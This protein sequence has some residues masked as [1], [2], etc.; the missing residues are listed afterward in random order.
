MDLHIF[1]TLNLFN[2]YGL[3]CFGIRECRHCAVVEILPSVFALFFRMF[4]GPFVVAQ[5]KVNLLEPAVIVLVRRRRRLVVEAVSE[6]HHI[7]FSLLVPLVENHIIDIDIVELAELDRR[8]VFDEIFFG[9]LVEVVAVVGVFLLAC[10]L[11]KFDV[12]R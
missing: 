9:F 3:L 2:H 4:V 12:N 1:L 11:R 5:Q 10:F 8:C 6:G 7:H